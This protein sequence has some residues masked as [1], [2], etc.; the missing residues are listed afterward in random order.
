VSARDRGIG[1]ACCR[2]GVQRKCAFAY[3]PET[4]AGTPV[5]FAT[6]ASHMADRAIAKVWEQTGAKPTAVLVDS[7]DYPLLADE[8][9]VGPGDTVGAEVVRSTERC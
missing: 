7:A 9:A 2:V 5:T 3:A 1:A 6:S 4:A 8:A